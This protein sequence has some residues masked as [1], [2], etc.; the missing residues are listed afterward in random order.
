VLYFHPW[1][2]DPDQPVISAVD[3]LNHV[4]QYRNLGKLKRILPLYL[5]EAPFTSISRYLGLDLEYPGEIREWSNKTIACE[6]ISLC[7][8]LDQKTPA[9]DACR[10]RNNPSLQTK[11]PVTVAIPCYNESSSIPYLDK[12]LAELVAEGGAQYDFHFLFVDDCSQDDTV[13]KLQTHFCHHHNCIIA[14]HDRN[15]GV[16]AA[17]LTGILSA[18]TEIV[19]TIDAD[20]SY[21]PLELLKMIPLMADEVAMI[22]ASP[23][24]KD[25]FVLG[26]PRWRLFLS[27]SLSWM[28]HGL[29]HHKLATYTSC[30]RVCRRSAMA[31]ISPTYEDFR[32]I[33][34]Q[35][36]RLDLAGA[37]I[38]EYPTTLQ[39]RIF[40]SSKMKIVKTIFGHLG[41]IAGLV[42][43]KLFQR[44]AF[45]R[46]KTFF[47]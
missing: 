23:Y 2:L 12:A 10:K 1:E 5:Q 3:K 14:Q 46:P 9:D 41:L 40:G 26:V 21:D 42:R 6:T 16:A 24:H 28:Y 22:T 31:E 36:A 30:F 39:S 38:V 45:L 34:E 18:P 27:K 43:F 11:L 17:L 7:S 44:I 47:L 37:R 8:A 25:G 20:C 33:I 35:L 29:L 4:R 32:G 13:A 15:R 19:C